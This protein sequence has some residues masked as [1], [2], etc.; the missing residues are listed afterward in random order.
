MFSITV[1]LPGSVYYGAEA[2]TPK[3]PEWPPHPS[4]LYSALVAAAARGHLLV[5]RHRRALEWVE[6]LGPP[7]IYAPVARVGE[8][9]VVY[10]PPADTVGR[11]GKKGE[12]QFEHPVDRWRQPRH[13]PAAIIMGTPEITFNWV[14]T[15]DSA[16]LSD[17]DDIAQWVTHVG[18]SPSI[19]VVSVSTEAKPPN[20][21]PDAAGNRFLR[22]ARSGRL[23]E[24]DRIFTAKLGVRRPPPR[25][26]VVVGYRDLLQTQESAAWSSADLI[27]FRLVGGYWTADDSDAL[28][29]S[30]RRSIM[31]ILGDH[32]PSCVHGHTGDIRIG[33][34]PLPD[35]GHENAR[36]RIVG[37]GIVIPK[38]VLPA[39][40][41]QLLTALREL[42]TI[43]LTGGRRFELQALPPGEF[44]P[45]ALQQATW[46]G[47]ATTWTSVTPVVLDRPPKRHTPEALAAALGV[48]F[49]NAGFPAPEIVEISQYSRLAGAPSTFDVTLSLPRYHA[50]V[51][52]EQAVEGPVIAGRLR[53]FGVGLFRPLTSDGT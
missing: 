45:K 37:V 18:T 39:D 41:M 9:P 28:G 16:T 10:V 20:M 47:P 14:E 17:L 22:V 31:S 11:K 15:A 35:V 19:A 30:I 50:T 4:R 7:S 13:F 33:W 46:L 51:R 8:F 23:A 34:L 12:E 38:S 49:A 36:G 24:L 42:E 26:E 2:D 43:R 44:V 6:T 53:N 21:I 5:D 48:C 3:T 32:A 52:F 29:K 40:R 1:G 27:V 25:C